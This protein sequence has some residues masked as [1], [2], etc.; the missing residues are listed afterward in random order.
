MMIAI[1]SV[2]SLKNHI[3]IKLVPTTPKWEQALETRS[4]ITDLLFYKT[5]NQVLSR[6]VMNSVRETGYVCNFFQDQDYMK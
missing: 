2:E 3:T 5:N 6:I 4:G 1:T